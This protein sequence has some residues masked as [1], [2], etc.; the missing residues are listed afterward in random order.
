[1]QSFGFPDRWELDGVREWLRSPCKQY[2]F[3]FRLLVRSRRH[4]KKMAARV[5]YSRE[6]ESGSLN[7]ALG[8]IFYH[9]VYLFPAGVS[10]PISTNVVQAVFFFRIY[11]TWKHHKTIRHPPID[12]VVNRMAVGTKPADQTLL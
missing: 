10:G 7:Q 11:Y 9:R 12:V 4:H 6:Y 2:L 3:P 8:V 1:M 5:S